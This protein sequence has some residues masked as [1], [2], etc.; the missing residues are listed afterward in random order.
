MTAEEVLRYS[1]DSALENNQII[2]HVTGSRGKVKTTGKL[3]SLGAMGLITALLVVAAVLFSSGN[4]IPSAISERLIEETDVQYADAVESKKLVFQQAMKNGELPENTIAVL[5]QYGVEVEKAENGEIVLKTKDK[6]V[7][8]DDFITVVSSD[9]NLYNAFDQATYSRAAYYFDDS[10]KKIFKEIG[11]TRN[12]YT[13]DSNFDEVMGSLVGSGSNIDVNNVVATEDEEGGSGYESAGAVARSSS[14]AEEFISG[15]GAQ[16][17]AGSSTEATLNSADS[18][19][20]ADTISKEQRSSLFFLTF[21]E[22][23]SKMKAGKGDESKINEAMNFLYEQHETEVVNVKTGEIMK[24]KGTAL[25]SPSLY[26]VLSGSKVNLE[27]AENY[28]SDRVLKTI[29]NRLGTTNGTGAITGTVASA[30][31]NIKGSIGRF[32]DIGG[33]GASV[34]TLNIVNK[35]IDGSLVNNSY[36]TINGVDAGEMLVEGAVNVGKKLAKASGATA[37]D[38]AAVS[39]YARLNSAVLAMDAEADRMNRSPF[40]VTSKN[41]FLGSI[42]HKLAVASTKMSG[43]LTSNMKTIASLTSEAVLGLLPASYADAASGFL[44]EFGDCETYST[45]G[46][47]GSPQCSE[48]ATFDTSTLNDTFND[49]EFIDFVNNNTTLSASGKRTINKGSVLADFVLYNDERTTP[50]GVTDGGILNSLGNELSS[51]NFVSNILEMIRS[52]LGASETEKRIASGAEYVN[53]SSNPN[54]GQYKY[55]QRYVSLARATESLQQYAGESSAYNNVYGFEGGE[56]PVIAFMN[57]Y[58]QTAQR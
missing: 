8:A 26:A 48:V 22:N 51:V 20:V 38:A 39:E 13:K 5:G 18:L 23:I 34:E 55:A 54:W 37:G 44:T 14:G 12:N 36:E 52:F 4:L 56:N 1:E 40:D 42:L 46:A 49:P 29:E 53:S 11:T 47:V 2:S 7:T 25:D 30:D 24:V 45:I 32:L 17:R 19:K 43:T 21:M 58:Y 27:G 10:A 15:V 50:L 6:T 31:E 9:V 35:T 3:K 57:D 33:E 16:T 41:T 28:S